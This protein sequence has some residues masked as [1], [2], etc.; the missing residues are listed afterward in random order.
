MGC[1]W[2]DLDQDGDLDLVLWRPNEIVMLLNRR[3][4]MFER[5]DPKRTDTRKAFQPPPLPESPKEI[6]DVVATDLDADGDP[7]ILITSLDGVRLWRNDRL[8]RFADVT[9]RAGLAGTSNYGR[10]VVADVDGDRALDIVGNTDQAGTQVFR[11]SS[12]GP[13]RLTFKR[14]E[15]LHD[16]F[17]PAAVGDLD[18]DGRDE[19]VMR[20]SG[21]QW[22]AIH[23]LGALLAGDRGRESIQVAARGP[24][25]LLADLNGDLALDLVVSTNDRR[26]GEVNDAGNTRVYLGK[27]P[28]QNHAL[29]IKL[30]GKIFANTMHSNM[31]GIGAR[32]EVMAGNR[33][34]V[35]EMRSGEGNTLHFGLGTAT[36]ADYV[37]IV[38]PDDVLQSEGWVPADQIK[39]IEE[40]QRKASSCPILFAW[41]GERFECV[42][43]FLGVGGLGFFIE[44]G[45]YGPPDPTEQILIP[46]LEPKDGKLELRIHEPF[47][48]ITYLDSAKLIVVDHPAD[49]DVV[50]DERFAINSPQPDGKLL[51]IR[52]R[53]DP[54]SAR[55]GRGQD[56]L[57]AVVRSDRKHAHAVADPRFIGYA[58][59]TTF[60]LDFGPGLA[61]LS[62]SDRIYVA[63]DGWVEYP[64]SHINLAA[65]QAGVRLEALSIEVEVA[66]KGFIRIQN[67][68]GY[69]AGMPR[70][71]T[72]PL[73]KLPEGLTGKLRLVTNQE[74]WIDRVWLFEP[75]DAKIQTLALPASRADLRFVGF[76]REYS[77]DG[78]AP[79]LYDY[80][81][82]DPSFPWKTMAGA[83]T[84][85]GEVGEILR[86]ADDCYVVFGPGEEVALTFDAPPPPAPGMKRTYV[87][88]TFGW[89]KDM[90]P[91]TAHP[92]TVEPLPFRGMSNYPYR[93]DESF[94]D[95]AAQKRWRAEYQ[96]R[97]VP[98]TRA[99]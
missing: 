10:F 60:E 20:S 46:K 19:L 18:S 75:A 66:G 90:D 74:L 91:Y 68:A 53:I 88:D 98:G 63:L 97:I 35:R 96:T 9:A 87:L 22:L 85:F 78:G 45:V 47:E 15:I 24:A 83:Y 65:W 16:D 29:E 94:P 33:F 25:V 1:L 93:D 21:M 73:G 28:P 81:I 48:E 79:R 86:E 8:M 82:I 59:P 69:P 58:E 2:S 70:I 38:W 49:V 3:D 55:D 41:N 57:D 5:F 54:V 40:F 39:V 52:K 56:A 14:S 51:A 76:P 7:D 71:T 4:G 6:S 37:R 43:D 30:Q 92:Y 23:S 50:P 44:P 11:Q 34:Q 13:F 17:S 67:E 72:F 84:R 32:V 36:A 42:T 64:Y 61:A 95:G 89:C 80:G 27:K 62:G 26:S 99:R 77:P 31:G 12:S